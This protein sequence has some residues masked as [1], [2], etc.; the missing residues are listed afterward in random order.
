MSRMP[1]TTTISDACCSIG[2]C[3][4]FHRALS[5]IESFR[6]GSLLSK[7]APCNGTTLRNGTS[8]FRDSRGFRRRTRKARYHSRL[9]PPSR[10]HQTPI[11]TR[12]RFWPNS[13]SDCQERNWEIPHG[14]ALTGS[15]NR[16]EL[17]C[18]KILVSYRQVRRRGVAAWTRLCPA[19]ALAIGGFVRSRWRGGRGGAMGFACAIRDL[20]VAGLG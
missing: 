17:N 19:G 5:T 16:V 18:R 6:P 1:P 8:K 11:S 10:T 4:I 20:F 3:L 9:W 12:L 7:K 2:P 13:C 15:P 14:V